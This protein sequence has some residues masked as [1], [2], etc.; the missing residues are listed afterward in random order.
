MLA[1]DLLA[2]R[3]PSG[4]ATMLGLP[5]APMQARRPGRSRYSKALPSVPVVRDI[6]KTINTNNTNNSPPPLPP[7]PDA[8]SDAGSNT[9]GSRPARDIGSSLY[10]HS[11]T[12]IARKPVGS[13]SSS[14]SSTPKPS[15]S[16]AASAASSASS[17]STAS[18]ASS[19]SPVLPTSWSAGSS[20]ASS[21][22][23]SV[24]SSAPPSAPSSTASSNMI[25]RRPVGGPLHPP[26]LR[27][28]IPPPEP[29]PTD[30]ICSLLSAYAREPDDSLSGSTYTTASTSNRIPD[31]R[32]SR[33]QSSSSTA[34][35]DGIPPAPPPKGG[36]P[37]SLDSQL[38][39]LPAAPESEQ[40]AS[41]NPEP[42]PKPKPKLWKRPSQTANRNK[43]LPDLRLNLPCKPT[44]FI[45]SSSVP[46]AVTSS[47]ASSDTIAG[48]RVAAEESRKPL[49]PPRPP[50]K[51][52]PGRDVRLAGKV[53]P[54]DNP[55]CSTQSMG[56]IA[57]KV[58]KIKHKWA[59]SSTKTSDKLSHNNNNRTPTRPDTMRPPT[60]EYRKGDVNPP[61]TP[62]DDN[63]KKPASPVSATGSSPAGGPKTTSTRDLSRKPLPQ[64][65]FSS[66][67]PPS[68]TETRS[69][70]PYNL[71]SMQSATKR[72][73]LAA[74]TDLCLA[75]TS[76]ADAGQRRSSPS[77]D[78][79]ASP[80]KRRP[81]F[82]PT[83]NERGRGPSK[84]PDSASNRFYASASASASVPGPDGL[85]IV[86]DSPRRPAMASG[87]HDPRIVYSDTQEPMY[88]GRDGTLYSEMKVLENPDPRAFYFPRQT[89]MTD[90][91][92]AGADTV[93]AS[94][95]LSQSHF[96]CFH[97]HKTM[98][99]RSN[100]HY[101]LTCQTCDK[102]D[103]EDRWVCTFCHLRI[104]DSC[105]RA[106]NGHQRVLQNLVDQL[107]KRSPLSLSSL[108]R[109]GSAP[110]VDVQ[111]S[112]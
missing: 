35:T 27:T 68:E 5:G 84:S 48:S 94:K 25:P 59:S 24:P 51:G 96:N 21:V 103:T 9:G 63:T 97:G 95:P 80:A 56:S 77:H 16:S 38:K 82:P 43:E 107:S 100:R 92:L 87:G 111:L 4:M 72:K 67:L 11:V 81:K 64:P 83:P 58:T 88:R 1:T 44:A 26:P 18:T 60:P 104:C 98:N 93:I 65:I 101:S 2:T 8:G 30:S 108:S 49:T 74:A 86:A 50:A 32:N 70:T 106:L 31:S 52:L 54:P 10:V 66:A 89:D 78:E 14:S 112:A 15:M 13:S 22:P 99:R 53:K 20:A 39:P 45:S 17:A 34:A 29:S 36:D 57:S 90:K 37:D 75:T 73:Q 12:S 91:P 85:G 69:A 102:A 110:G 105:L 61:S 42:K 40:T 6:D 3:L 33:N 28:L 41:P 79:A 109:S 46:S 47:R 23:S 7:I 19:C 71:A 55:S 76:P 62:G